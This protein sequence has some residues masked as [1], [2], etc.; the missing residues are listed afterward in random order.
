MD[1]EQS[2]KSAIDFYKMYLNKNKVVEKRTWLNVFEEYIELIKLR[3][4][5]KQVSNDTLVSWQNKLKL[6]QK[7]L[8]YHKKEN[9]NIEDISRGE[10][11][12][13]HSY[14]SNILGLKNNYISKVISNFKS[15]FT[16]AFENGYIKL[17]PFS[18]ISVKKIENE[19]IYL[20]QLEVEKIEQF[21]PKNIS[22]QKTKD[23]FLFQCYTGIDYVDLCKLK[24]TNLITIENDIWLVYQRQKTK[25]K[26]NQPKASI[27]LYQFPKALELIAKYN[28]LANFPKMTNQ[29]F[30]FYLKVI[31]EM[32]GIEKKLH[33]KISRKTFAMY[34]RNVLGY[35]LDAVAVMLGDKDL[36]IVQEHY[37]YANI[38]KLLNEIRDKNRK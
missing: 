4:S 6:L 18:N 30:N 32:V 34:A 2:N 24:S 21:K 12:K 5:N 11:L 15:V 19:I 1:I 14:L 31:G 7:Y 20:T 3:V 8:S 25:H 17:N 23:F 36:K 16:F 10:Y 13:L 9:I 38:D 26:A 28:S 35:S 27:P 37:T 29:R 22:L 33:T